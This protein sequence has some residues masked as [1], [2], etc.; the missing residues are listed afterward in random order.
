[1]NCTCPN[2]GMENAYFEILDEK[3]V[4]YVCPDCDHEWCDTSITTS[5]ETDYDEENQ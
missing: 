4:H 5:E 1:M 3:G 2:C